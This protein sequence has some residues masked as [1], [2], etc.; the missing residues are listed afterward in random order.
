[1]T[2]NQHQQLIDLLEKCDQDIRVIRDTQQ[3]ILNDH[4][5]HIVTVENILQTIEQLKA[6]QLAMNLAIFRGSNGKRSLLEDIS[7]TQKSTPHLEHH[8]RHLEDQISKLENRWISL[9]WAIS[10]SVGVGVLTLLLNA[11]RS[12]DEISSDFNPH[13]PPPHERSQPK[14][15]DQLTEELYK[16]D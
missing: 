5:R 11:F 9:L 14:P 10:F 3:Q 12:E 16:E 13:R 1:M 4:A 8:A 15:E 7:S 6:D 2:D